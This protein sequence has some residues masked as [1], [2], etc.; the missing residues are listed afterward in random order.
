MSNV[1]NTQRDNDMATIPVITGEHQTCAMSGLSYRKTK[2]AAPMNDPR[3]R[4]YRV[5]EAAEQLGIGRRKMYDLLDANLIS[6]VY[7]GRARRIPSDE[8]DRYVD[9]LRRPA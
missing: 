1:P 9:T 5:T 3:K 4:L 7:I 6:S 8:L 2:G